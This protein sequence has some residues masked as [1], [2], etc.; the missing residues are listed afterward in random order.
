[1][2]R[3][4]RKMDD[5][6]AT[7]YEKLGHTDVIPETYSRYR[8]ILDRYVDTNDGYLVL[9]EMLE[10][11]HP[12][13]K[14]DPIQRP[15]TSQECQDD[16]QEYS[17]RF[18][19]Y[20]VSEQLNGRTY[21]AR[22]QVVLFLKGLDTEF[23]PAIQY[24]E[25]L[26]DSWGK[27][28][29]NPKCEI[30][31]LPRTIESF[32]KTHTAE[33]TPIM[34][35][36]K[37]QDVTTNEFMEMI[38]AANTRDGLKRGKQVTQE[39]PRKSIDIYCDA[40][41]THGHG[42]RNCDFLAK[43]LKAMEFMANIDPTKKKLLLETYQKEQT[44]KRQAKHGNAVARAAQCLEDNDIQGMYALIQELHPPELDQDL[45]DQGLL[46]QEGSE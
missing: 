22:E 11:E 27:E 3:E 46:T 25:T 37:L 19:S 39:A 4:S 24:V 40:C 9:Y 33:S 12:A 36:T 43:L 30:R 15:P 14:Q 23:T 45:M 7:L 42:W 20:L 13:M 16:I 1:M 17:A 10:D 6:A 34:R 28:G 41:G 35:A 26:M 5:M 29:L 18:T 44:C 38:R 32:M 2:A 21:R 8:N 31:Y